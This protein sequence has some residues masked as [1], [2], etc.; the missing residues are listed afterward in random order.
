LS[1]FDPE[2]E[3]IPHAI[4]RCLRDDH[5]IDEGRLVAVKVA[6][7]R[8]QVRALRLPPQMKAKETSSRCE[9][10]VEQHGEDVYE[11]EAVPPERLQTI[12]RN[13]I[14]GVL[15]VDAFNAEID[16]ERQD[17]ADLERIRQSLLSRLGG[18]GG[19]GEC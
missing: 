2:G 12:L 10:F 5:G 14:D 3:D 15:D 18:T 17:T 7:R 4:V 1:D 9:K 6:L 19:I 11:L 13:G 8:E 16:Q